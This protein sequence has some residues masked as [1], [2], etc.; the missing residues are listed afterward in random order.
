MTPTTTTTDASVLVC[1]SRSALVSTL[2]SLIIQSFLASSSRPS[3]VLAASGGSL[4]S[5]L[6]GLASSF[7]AAG[8]DPQWHRWHVLLVDERLVPESS[9]DSNMGAL[10][11]H[12]SGTPEGGC[13]VPEGQVRA[14]DYGL[15]A[16]DG[17]ADDAAAAAVA[18]SYGAS[19]AA[20]LAGSGGRIDL[21]LLGFGPD[22][23]TASL[24]PG[25]AP[26]PADPTGYCA[27]LTDSPKP[28]P[29]RITL[30]L[31]TLNDAR[32]CVLVG[33]GAGKRAVLGAVFAGGGG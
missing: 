3:F 22:G 16:T 10:R 19:V 28:P 23:H 33:S 5:L 8:V 30:T 7:E 6:S 26:L 24:F 32:E 21:C 1:P 17:T 12:L 15:L 2:H 31:G 25:H 29:C 11:Q 13:A 27:H 18:A 20:A 4:P 14:I 9:G